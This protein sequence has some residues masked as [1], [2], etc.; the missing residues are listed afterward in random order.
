MPLSRLACL[1]TAAFMVIA[2][3][4]PALANEPIPE[5]VAAEDTSLPNP[6]GHLT[7][8]SPEH[9]AM[10]DL[11]G[12]WRVTA[13]VWADSTAPPNVTEGRSVRTLILGGRVL[14]EL[15]TSSF[16]GRP[17]EGESL[18]GYDVVTG[19][20][21][22]VW[23]DSLNTGPTI[24]SGGWDEAGEV[25]VMEGESSCLMCGQVIPIRIESQ[26]DGPDRGVHA[27]FTPDQD[28]AMIQYM[29]LTYDRE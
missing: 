2:I 27:F 28:G 16:M 15:Y 3:D 6:M 24:T 4:H 22:G 20:Y 7:Q 11:V 13:R 1:S 9:E 21:W 10:A 26:M 5:P 14:E 23:T 8:L 25:F 18:T 17:F 29:E 12:A 19:R